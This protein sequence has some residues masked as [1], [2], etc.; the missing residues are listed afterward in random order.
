MSRSQLRNLLRRYHLSRIDRVGD[1]YDENWQRRRAIV[2][3]PHQ[4]DE[5]LG[6][7]GTVAKKIAVG[8][9]LQV[10][11]MTDGCRSHSHLMN[12]SE[13]RLVRRDEVLA[14]THALGID[15]SDVVFLDFKDGTLSKKLDAAVDRVKAL[16]SEYKPEEVFVP[17]SRD[18]VADHMATHQ[19]VT[20][21]LDAL[22][23]DVIVNEYPIWFWN[24]WPWVSISSGQKN[25]SSVLKNIYKTGLSNFRLVKYFRAP[26]YI[27]DVLEVKRA[28]LNHYQS[29][30]TR[31]VSTPAWKTL[32]DVSSGEF[33]ECFLHDY[34]IFYRYRSAHKENL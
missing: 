18:G 14:A 28:A 15:G 2:F 11:F 10:V 26:V 8:A 3:S 30:M 23:V 24:H 32:S 12:E 27:G 22:N 34:E 5:T 6:C 9:A 25:R 16:I 1:T 13:L 19:I 29:Q 20:R 33:L 21:A 7:G 17:Y 31:L 4:D